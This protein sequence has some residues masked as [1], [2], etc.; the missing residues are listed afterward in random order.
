MQAVFK[1]GIEKAIMGRYFEGRKHVG[2]PGDGWK[3][4]VF[5][6]NIGIFQIRNLKSA[7]RATEVWRKEIGEAT[8]RELDEEILLKKKKK[9]EN[10]VFL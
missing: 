7:A 9:T 5:K 1:S 8:S 2:K 10:A 6:Y 3:N 4:A